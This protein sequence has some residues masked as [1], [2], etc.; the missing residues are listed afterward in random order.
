MRSLLRRVVASEV[1]Q[2]HVELAAESGV[3]S[4]VV[5]CQRVVELRGIHC[6]EWSRVAALVVACQRV[7]EPHEI[8]YREWSRVAALVVACQRVWIYQLELDW[9]V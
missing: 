9:D 1:A 6:R 7:V 2:G 4:I 5:T 8:H 3:M